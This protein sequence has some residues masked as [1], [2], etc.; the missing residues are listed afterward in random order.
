MFI[1]THAHLCDERFAPDRDAILDR[2]REKGVDAIIE[3][4]CER[5]SWE[6]TLAFT[7]SSAALYCALGLH[8][9]EAKLADN[10]T[11]QELKRLCAD[12]KVVAIG[13]TG[14][15]YHFEYSPRDIQKKVFVQHLTI[16][17]ELEKP[18][19]IHCREAYPD[20]IELL[21]TDNAKNGLPKGVI[22]CFSGTLVEAERL[23]AL[24]F[25]LGVD[26]PV[27]YPSAKVLQQVVERI[28]LE[29]LLLETDAPYLPPQLY[30]GQRNESSYI[31]LIA[32]QIAAIKGM[33]VETVGTI[34]SGNAKEL[35]R[36]K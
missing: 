27:T 35:F 24:G 30:R 34:T 4:G 22:H 3:I 13:E 33:P 17:R 29:K 28:P 20:L 5:T 8:P 12:D 7:R 6:K 10:D 25:L 15:D 1:D 32:A 26:G 16:A 19:V 18:M 11:W 21:E 9:Q 2:A 23:L 31:P 36:L 14:L